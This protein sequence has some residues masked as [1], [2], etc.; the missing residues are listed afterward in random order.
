M[1]DIVTP[2]STATVPPAAPTPP[3]PPATPPPPKPEYERHNPSRLAPLIGIFVIILAAIAL[4]F[5]KNPFLSFFPPTVPPVPPPVTNPAPEPV[6]PPLAPPA[7]EAP[8]STPPLASDVATT[9][10]QTTSTYRLGDTV[11]FFLNDD[12]TFADAKNPQRS[13]TVT[14]VEFTDSR[15]PKGVVCVWQGEL[16][17][18]LRVTDRRTGQ[19]EDVSLGMV[20]TKTATALG[21][22]FTL[23]EIDEGK[24][25]T[26]ASVTV[27]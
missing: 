21:L 14:A 27:Q 1:P 24:G 20:R 16:G 15:C 25:G 11:Q 17:V 12:V 13:F 10:Q 8:S 26:F 2:P 7:E 23:R 9:T 22:R 3:V 19:S 5:L 4:L 18:R 6:V